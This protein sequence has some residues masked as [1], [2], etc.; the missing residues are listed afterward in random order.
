MLIKKKN[1]IL[2]T[3]IFILMLMYLI[4]ICRKSKENF[5][6]NKKEFVNNKKVIIVHT[7]K[8]YAYANHICKKIKYE[9]LKTNTYNLG[10]LYSEQKKNIKNQNI[11]IHPRTA[12]PL[13]SKWIILLKELEKEGV[14]VVNPP[15]LLQLTSNKLECSFVLY[16]NGINHPKTWKGFK[17]QKTLNL[18]KSLLKKHEKLIIKPSN[19]ISQG[20]YVKKIEQNNSD[21]EISKK[22]E[23][24]PTN[25]F[26]IQEYVDYIALYRVIVINGQAL[27][28]SFID[29][30]TKDNWKVSVCLNRTRMKFVPN[31]DKRILK[32][33]V[34][35]QNVLNKYINNPYKGIHFIDIFETKDNKFTISE[36]NTACSLFIHERLA[37]DAKHPNW[38][39]S[40]YIAEYLNSL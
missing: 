22:I 26:V 3:F 32:L 39:I 13:D 18:I 15:R 34:D 9:C 29:K 40:K 30:P 24:I 36:I 37:K 19:S 2:I 23:S 31:P 27:P 35:T 7:N 21:I 20:A 33:G 17:D 38:E 25:P 1:L 8:S 16:N 10:I 11:I 14:K 4:I 12:T 5:D 6:N 28:F